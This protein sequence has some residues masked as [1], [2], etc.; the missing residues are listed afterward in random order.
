VST[1]SGGSVWADACSPVPGG[2]HP[3]TI[4]GQA[5]LGSFATSAGNRL[6]SAALGR[7]TESPP[8]LAGALRL[9]AALR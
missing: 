7:L 1:R 8:R 2:Y 9:G 6:G 3:D 4:L 5:A